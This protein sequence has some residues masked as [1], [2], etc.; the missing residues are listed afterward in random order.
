MIEQKDIQKQIK[1]P[2][3]G[4]NHVIFPLVEPHLAKSFP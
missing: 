4:D 3:Y 1:L 2:F